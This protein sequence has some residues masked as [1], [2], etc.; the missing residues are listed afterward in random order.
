MIFGSESIRSFAVALTVGLIV[1][2]ITSVYIATPLWVVLKQKELKQKGVIV[3]FKEKKVRTDEPLCKKLGCRIFC[4]FFSFQ[5]SYIET[6]SSLLYNEMT[7]VN[8]C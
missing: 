3:T 1:G 2:T 7:E 6:N 4:S 5:I 8:V